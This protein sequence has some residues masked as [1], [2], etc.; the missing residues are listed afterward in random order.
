M[1]SRREFL[2]TTAMAVS[3][4]A[5]T[6]PRR[7]RVAAIHTCYHLKSHSYHISGRFLYGYPVGGIHHQPDFKIVRMYNDQYPSNDLSRDLAPKFGFELSNSVADALGGGGGLDVDAVLLIGEHG[8]YPSN[9]IGQ[10][11]YPRHK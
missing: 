8:N 10:Q 2:A 11:L 5:A 7:K 1:I 6:A 3:S 4:L 9:E